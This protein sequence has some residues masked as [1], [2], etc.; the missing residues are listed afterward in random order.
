MVIKHAEDN[1]ATRVVS[2]HLKVGE[3]RDFIEEWV[4]SYFDHLSRGTIAE[5]AKIKV[6]KV[7]LQLKCSHCGSLFKAHT[8]NKDFSCPECACKDNDLVTGNEYCID[9]IG[10]I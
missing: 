8:E 10:V 3:L 2:V 9:S 1:G 6:E 7:P 4:Q 5:G